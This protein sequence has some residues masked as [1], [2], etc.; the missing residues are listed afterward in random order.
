MRMNTRVWWEHGAGDG[1][2]AG[3]ISLAEYLGQRPNA[4]VTKL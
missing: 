2:G 4:E 3:R 1:T